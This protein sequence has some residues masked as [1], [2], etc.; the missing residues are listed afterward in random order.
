MIGGGGIFYWM[1]HFNQSIWCD[2]PLTYIVSGEELMKGEKERRKR[3][4][5]KIEEESSQVKLVKQEEE[6]KLVLKVK[7]KKKVREEVNR[8]K[9]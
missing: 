4:R 8:N 2:F 3:I 1:P 9:K 6:K 5:E 7:E